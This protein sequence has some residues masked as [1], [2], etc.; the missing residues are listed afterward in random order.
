MQNELEEL[1]EE[2]I[3]LREANQELV[4]QLDELY[5]KVDLLSATLEDIEHFSREVL[6]K[7]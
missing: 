6:K 5:H 1:R 4:N 3:T 7:V 2:V